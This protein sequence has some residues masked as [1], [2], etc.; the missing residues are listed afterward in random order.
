[1]ILKM[2]DRTVHSGVKMLTQR[3]S[4]RDIKSQELIWYKPGEHDYKCFKNFIHFF[5]REMQ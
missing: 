4:Y 3:G 2:T 5:N 1:M